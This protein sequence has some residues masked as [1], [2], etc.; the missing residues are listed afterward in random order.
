MLWYH[1]LLTVPFSSVLQTLLKWREVGGYK[2][3][4]E[5]W[6]LSGKISNQISKTQKSQGA[7]FV[8]QIKM[9]FFDIKNI[10]MTVY[11]IFLYI[12]P[13]HYEKRSKW[14]KSCPGNYHVVPDFINCWLSLHKV[15]LVLHL[16]A[17]RL[18]LFQREGSWR[19]EPAQ[20]STNCVADP[21]RNR[22]RLRLKQVMR[23]H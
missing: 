20:R 9:I 16:V 1:N 13:M 23:R 17:S 21:L 2:K 11:L 4:V 3:K 6:L 8:T 7:V 12:D 10:L 19:W 14:E 15:A 18:P 22:A 5:Y